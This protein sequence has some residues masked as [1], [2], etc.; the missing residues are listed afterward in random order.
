M[1][2]TSSKDISSKDIS[3][4]DISSKDISIMEAGSVRARVK[5][6]RNP[7]K[8]LKG[9]YRYGKRDLLK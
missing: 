3:S 4:K 6:P 2:D 8:R 7:G 1:C 5:E 9:S